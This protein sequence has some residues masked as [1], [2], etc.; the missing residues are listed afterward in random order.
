MSQHTTIFSAIHIYGLVQGIGYRPFVKQTA[1]QF[2]IKGSVRNSGGIVIIEAFAEKQI[3]DQ[4]IL[5]LSNH[6]LEGGRID[7]INRTD[8]IS[9]TFPIEFQIIASTNHKEEMPPLIPADIATCFNCEKE[10]LDSKN[11]RY[12]HPFISCVTCGPRYSIIKELP[13]DRQNITMQ[14]FEM[15]EVCKSEYDQNSK[16]LGQRRTYAQTIACRDCGPRL[17]LTLSEKEKPDLCTEDLNSDDYIVGKSCEI[18]LNG[19]ILALKDIG[20]FHLVCRADRKET[21]ARMR[22]VKGREKKPFAIMFRD[23]SHIQEYCGLSK[24]EEELLMSPAR[25]IVLIRN[26]S[27]NVGNSADLGA[28][29]PCNPL[30]ILILEKLK[31]IPLIMTSANRSGEPIIIEN[32]AMLKWQTQDSRIQAVV[33]HNRDIVTPLDD[34]I[35]RSVCGKIQTIRRARGYVPEPIELKQE[36]RK[37][38]TDGTG[39]TEQ[40]EIFAAGGDLKS[41]FCLLKGNRAYLSQHFG[42]LENEKIIA[43]YKNAYVRMADLLNIMPSYTVYDKHPMYSSSQIGREMIPDEHRHLAVQHHFSHAAAVMAEH[44]LEGR[45]FAVVFDGTGYGED[46]TVWGG[47]F[48]LMDNGCTNED[49]KNHSLNI[50]RVGSISPVSLIGGN[51]GSKNARSSMYAYLKAGAITEEELKKYFS[52]TIHYHNMEQD[53]NLD[54]KQKLIEYKTVST[55]IDIGINRITSTST[56]RLFDSVSALLGIC[57]FNRYEGECAVLLEKAAAEYAEEYGAEWNLNETIMVE[58]T[59]SLFRS[60]FQKICDFYK[61]FYEMCDEKTEPDSVVISQKKV[62]TGRLAYEFHME[63]SNLIVEKV[64]KLCK[65]Y[66]AKQIA[67]AGG[68]FA[69][70]IL[71]EQITSALETKGYSVYFNEKVPCGDGGIAL[72]QAYIAKEFF[73]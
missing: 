33:Y 40:P 49:E 15:C 6:C 61:N 28:M 4:F 17:F 26:L 8:A 67:L 42:D 10:L 58:D 21:V 54:K 19:G 1:E 25:P 72:G 13:Y 18:L 53:F 34:S 30:Q 70:R 20:G 43:A 41:A 29:L 2:D 35:V 55:A 45:T 62:L 23:I 24:H 5:Y 50:E 31:N 51:G 65:Q 52:Y 36:K 57:D 68:T 11:R 27:A 7:K 66:D 48:I 14:D 73:S 64:I 9:E 3:I 38:Q 63:F 12:E 32:D 16:K 56:G 69:N 39:L 44:S 59:I 22:E 46:G 37:C 60:I 47:E 71:L